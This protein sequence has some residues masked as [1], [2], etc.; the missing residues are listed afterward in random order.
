MVCRNICER[1]YS[2]IVVGE[3]HYSVGR[4]IAGDA[5]VTLSPR[6]SFVNVVECSSGLFQVK[7]NAKKK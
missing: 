7:E 4:N 6:K 5:S 1:I 2:K 3:S